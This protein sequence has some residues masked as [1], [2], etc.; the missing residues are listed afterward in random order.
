[1][2]IIIPTYE[3]PQF[4]AKSLELISRQDYPNLEVIIVDDSKE[5]FAGEFVVQNVK[6]IHLQNR[7]TIGEKRNLAVTYAT[8]EIIVHWDDDDFFREHRVTAQVAPILSG[9]VSMTVL[10]HHYYFYLPTRTFYVVKRAS[11]WGPHFGTFVYHKR[12]WNSGLRY[13]DNSMAEDYAFAEEALQ[14]GAQIRIL[15]NEDGKHVYI[16][17]Y[18]TWDF[19]LADYDAQVVVVDRPSFFSEQDYD[20]YCALDVKPL[21]TPPKYYASDK[22]RWDRDELRP[23]WTDVATYP[24]YP[25]YKMYTLGLAAKVGIGVGVAGGVALIVLLGLAA[26]GYTQWKKK[27][28]QGYIPINNT[29]F[30]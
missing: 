1:V 9:E 10:E 26:Y 20:Y 19:N 23:A 13:P 3:R 22:I 24:A 4:L 5:S 14:T 15:N 28:E 29:N 21:S 8:G 2:S 17:H 12:L 30:D 25:S 27:K 11:S 7:I 16:R 6:Y 18:N